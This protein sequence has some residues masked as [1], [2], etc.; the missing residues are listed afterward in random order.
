MNTTRI[1]HFEAMVY[2]VLVSFCASINF[3]LGKNMLALLN[4]A[5]VVML[6]FL[7]PL[8]F[9]IWVAIVTKFPKRPEKSSFRPLIIRCFCFFLTQ[10]F[11]FWYLSHGSYVL[12]AVL[13]CTAPIF[14]P[15]A[16]W[17]IYKL[18]MSIKMWI[19]LAI[20]FIGIVLILDP[21]SQDWNSW[22]FLGLLSGFFSALGQVSFNQIAKNEDP[23]DTAFFLFLVG[24][25][26]SLC[27]VWITSNES[28]WLKVYDMLDD[29]KVVLTWVTFAAVTVLAQVFRS[30]SYSLVNKTASV[31]PLSYFTIIFSAFF[32]W[33][34]YNSELTLRAWFGV[35][36]VILGGIILLHRKSQKPIL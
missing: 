36:L 15:F 18:H 2:M 5:W 9:M 14:I 31:A 34:Y 6:R 25:I 27:V 35:F 22:A 13:S 19:S 21:G 16:D 28:E 30:K 23:K 20:S 3:L 4:P 29:G 1:Q 17:L 7:L 26:F 11:L 32:A 8:F 10:Y 33:Y 12:A 24:S